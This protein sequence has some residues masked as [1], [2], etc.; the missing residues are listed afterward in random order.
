MYLGLDAGPRVMRRLEDNGAIGRSLLALPQH[1]PH[2]LRLQVDLRALNQP[3]TRHSHHQASATVL[4]LLLL[5][6]VLVFLGFSWWGFL[7]F[8]VLVCVHAFHA[9]WCWSFSM[10]SDG[11]STA[12]H[13]IR[14]VSGQDWPVAT[15]GRCNQ[16]L[17]VAT[18]L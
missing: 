15:G 12:L 4:L 9:F 7:W 5:C 8:V 3:C 6:F 17:V 13:G 18:R 10:V 11:R 1:L 16:T 14:R 2:A